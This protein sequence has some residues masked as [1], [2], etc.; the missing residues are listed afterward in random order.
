MTE[1]KKPLHEKHRML[2]LKYF[3]ETSVKKVTSK[4]KKYFG[5]KV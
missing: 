3:A 5:K 1:K 4:A 2:A